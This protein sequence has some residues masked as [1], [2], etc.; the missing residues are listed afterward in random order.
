ML[1]NSALIVVILI[2][3]ACGHSKSPKARSDHVMPTRNPFV[4]VEPCAEWVDKP[5][6]VYAINTYCVSKDGAILGT[7]RKSK[8]DQLF[9]AFVGGDYCGPGHYISVEAA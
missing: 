3:S 6:D 5:T 7:V 4:H 9:D 1:K 8:T 2:L